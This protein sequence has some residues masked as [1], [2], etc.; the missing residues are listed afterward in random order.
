MP[1]TH[2]V[3]DADGK[4]RGKHW[5]A[6]HTLKCMHVAS[7]T[8][9]LNV[10]GVNYNGSQIIPDTY[11]YFS[12]DQF[13]PQYMRVYTLLDPTGGTGG[14][15]QIQVRNAGGILCAVAITGVT[16]ILRVGAW[17]DCSS[18][19]ADSLIWCYLLDNDGGSAFDTWSIGAEFR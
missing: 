8:L 10:D 1:I 14:A 6:D 3:L 2:T 17:T 5:K 7:R 13:L 19:T 9:F 16:K 4:I 12:F 15:S 18:E 11:T